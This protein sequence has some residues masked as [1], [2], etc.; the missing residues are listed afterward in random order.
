MW[1]DTAKSYCTLSVSFA[2]GLWPSLSSAATAVCLKKVAAAKVQLPGGSE[3][4]SAAPEKPVPLRHCNAFALF[5]SCDCASFPFCMCC[6]IS[7]EQLRG[8]G[9]K[10][11]KE[12]GVGQ[13]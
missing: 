10:R 8:Q 6:V 13:V 9:R 4:P 12:V 11:Y 7:A 5:I 2:A 3:S 1:R